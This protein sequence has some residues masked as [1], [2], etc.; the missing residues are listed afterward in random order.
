[1]KIFRLMTYGLLPLAALLW[2]P[3]NSGA[4]EAIPIG[5]GCGKQDFT[6]V[7]SRMKQVEA[8]MKE[9]D[10]LTKE[11][12]SKEKGAGESLTLTAA[13]RGSVQGSVGFKM[14]GARDSN[15]RSFAAE[16]NA[17]CEVEIDPSATRCL[18]GALEDHESVHKKACDANKSLNPFVD[19]RDKQR[20]VDY[21]KEEKA[22][23]QKELER[24]KEELEKM[25]KFCSLDPSRRAELVA[26]AA[27]K[28]KLEEAFRRIEETAKSLR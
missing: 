27:Q 25:K 19:W 11:W 14:S 2:F 3:S 15:A 13:N 7:E 10:A 9:Y 4:G 8:A 20:V 17:A 1:M 24:L 16:T 6:D 5:C 28:Q 12:E 22:G 21:M 23:Y 18:R 26:Q